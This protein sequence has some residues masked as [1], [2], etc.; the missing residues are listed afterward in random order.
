M[1]KLVGK[2]V[3]MLSG[4]ILSGLICKYLGMWFDP[5]GY[6]CIVILIALWEIIMI[7]EKIASSYLTGVK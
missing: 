6:L 3:M 2:T 7:L 5:I 1:K 4:M